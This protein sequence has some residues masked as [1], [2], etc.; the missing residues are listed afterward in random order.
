MA[1]L[2]STTGGIKNEV[3]VRLGIATTAAFY[4]DATIDEWINNAH[5]WAAGYKKW[6]MT[7]GRS[8]TT[9]ASMGTSEEGWT[10]LEYPEGFKTDSI[11]LLT[12]GGKKFLKKNFYKFQEFLENNSSDTS[13]IFSDFGRRIYIN[14]NAAGLSGTVTAYGQFL[15]ADLDKT[16]LNQGTIFTGFND[17]GNLA[18]VEEILS[19]AA[20]RERRSGPVSIAKHK[21]AMEILDQI[22]E[23]IKEEQFGYHDTL[24][25]GMFKRFDVVGGAYSDDIF[26]RDQF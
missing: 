10:V 8:S 19:Y 20:D 25:D 13:V 17:E 3:I 22:A 1:N 2:I 24:N 9:S 11:R 15:P 18:I 21:K 12:V 4:S 5:K 26:K 14:P 6:P 7:E 23:T 16:D